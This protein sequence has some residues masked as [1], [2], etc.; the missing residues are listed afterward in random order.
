MPTTSFTNGFDKLVDNRTDAEEEKEA[1]EAVGR[2]LG[3]G[4][5]KI[6]KGEARESRTCGEGCEQ[7]T[8][9][10]TMAKYA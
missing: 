3:N 1:R 2:T 10:P 9:L 6:G 4:L 7:T 8:E 5:R